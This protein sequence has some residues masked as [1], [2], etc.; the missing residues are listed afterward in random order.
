M[1]FNFPSSPTSGDTHTA[2]NGTTY[3]FDGAVWNSTKTGAGLPAGGSAGQFLVKDTDTNY[4]FTFKNSGAVGGGSDEVFYLN[5]QTVGTSY[6]VPSGQNAMSA[7]PITIA[8][9]VV[10]TISS[11]STWVVV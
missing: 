11:G 9:G 7:G 3:I 5:G 2:Q 6:T 8:D 10:V 4:D 1:A